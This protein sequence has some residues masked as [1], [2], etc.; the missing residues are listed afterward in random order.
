MDS[1]N[2]VAFLNRNF[3]DE[4]ALSDLSPFHA[5]IND[6]ISSLEC[7]LSH[8]VQDQAESSHLAM[9]QVE[10]AKLN[11]RSLQSTIHDIRLKAD[12]SESMVQEICRD[13]K[14]LDVA[15]R[16]L[17]LTLDTQKR[18]HMLLS[19]TRQLEEL[20]ETF[21]YQQCAHLIESSLELLVPFRT[22][23]NIRS[24]EDIRNRVSA[25]SQTLEDQ[26]TMDFQIS[27]RLVDLDQS[28][29]ECANLE[30]ACLVMVA[31]EKQAKIIQQLCDQEMDVYDALFGE[32]GQAFELVHAERR[33]VWFARYV[34]KCRATIQRIFP[35]SWRVEIALARAF[36]Q[37]T[38]SH[39][40][41]LLNREEH[42]VPTLLKTYQHTVQFEKKASQE[43]DP[44]FLGIITS[45]FDPYMSAYVALERKNMDDM[46]EQVTSTERVD[47]AGPLPVFSSSVN[48]FV[49]IR[50]AME[51]CTA[52]TNGQTLFHLKSEFQSCLRTY[53]HRLELKFEKSNKVDDKDGR[54]HH[55][56]PT[57][58]EEICFVINTCEY[59]AE[60]LSPL[61]DKL[62]QVIAS[63][64]ED[65]IDLG[66]EIETF[67]TVA[68][69]AMKS[70]LESLE[71]QVYPVLGQIPKLVHQSQG[72]EHTVGDSSDYT[73]Q[74]EQILRS[75]VP[76]VRDMLS[77]LY[78]TNFCDQCATALLKHVLTEILKC[79]RLSATWTQQLLLDTAALKT[80]FMDLPHIGPPDRTLTM[81][82]ISSRYL[83]LVQ[84]EIGHIEVMLKLIGTPEDKLLESFRL[85]WPTGEARD[86][87]QILAAKGLSKREQHLTLERFGLEHNGVAEHP[88]VA[89]QLSTSM[90]ATENLKRN[91]KSRFG[92]N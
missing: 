67:Q 38:K 36:A 61:E 20:A 46:I 13:I 1:F 6:T 79:T 82:A 27:A 10:L 12:S 29:R 52:L 72:L 70:L 7:E 89:P 81:P 39:L 2:I 44:N 34:A 48:M 30:M 92:F 84:H 32:E 28:P 74:V 43:Y 55:P 64:F 19:A 65:A 63:A 73:V 22:Y 58:E 62:R 53:A 33:Y 3:P 35:H 45:S 85:M 80:I 26:I 75:V 59:C 83:K 9:E 24:L 54:K 41:V 77:G 69:K 51:R 78:F 25:V 49:Y 68:M 14:Q 18:L 88:A 90:F 50:S 71:R 11:I 16:H 8:A 42:D 91:M 40:L 56:N 31:L 60:T 23:T 87:L 37:H 47:R 5:N 15:K 86:L 17:Q 21:E 57:M 4:N 66:N 76:V